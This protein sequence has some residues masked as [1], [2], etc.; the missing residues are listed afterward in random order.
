MR[1][2]VL[3]GQAALPD[4][5]KLLIKRRKWLQNTRSGESVPRKRCSDPRSHAQ[6]PG[7]TEQTPEAVE[8]RPGGT[9]Q[10]P[11]VMFEYPEQ[12]IEGGEA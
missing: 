7:G 8:P 10:A 4:A 12:Q 1:A 11:E 3:L 9:D 2:D 6:I 5:K